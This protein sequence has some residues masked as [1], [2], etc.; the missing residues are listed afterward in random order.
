MKSQETHSQ[1]QS[2]EFNFIDFMRFVYSRRRFVIFLTV[3]IFSLLLFYISTIQRSIFRAHGTVNINLATKSQS[4]SLSRF[5]NWIEE[6]EMLN[7]VFWT[8]QFFE[9]SAYRRA[10]IQE[11]EG[12][13]ERCIGDECKAMRK[14]IQGLLQ[15]RGAVNLV[16]KID[17]VFSM[18]EIR[19]DANK[20][21]LTIVS[22]SPDPQIA[23]ALTTLAIYTLV[24]LNYEY[25]LT[26]NSRVR[27]F[28]EGQTDATG[29]ELARLEKI[30][31]VEQ[32]K[33]N[34]LSTPETENKINLIHIDN[35]QRLHNLERDRIS[36]E[37]LEQEVVQQLKQFRKELASPDSVSHVFV[38]QLQRRFD[39][40]KYQMAL[41]SS[42]QREPSAATG[43]Q[44]EIEK[45]RNVLEADS[46]AIVA[47]D[48]W[49]IIKKV[50]IFLLEARQ[51]KEQIRSEIDAAKQA[52]KKWLAEYQTMPE[53]FRR[54]TE[55]KRNIQITT[56][57]YSSLKT[58]LQEINIQEAERAND[59]AIL[60]LPEVPTDP[61]GLT[62][63]KKVVLAGLAGPGFSI[64]LLLLNYVLVPLVRNAS[65]LEWLGVKVIGSM[66]YVRQGS[67]LLGQ[68]YPIVFNIDKNGYAANSFR[69]IRFA[70]ENHLKR[71][72]EEIGPGPVVTISGFNSGEG[73]TFTTV[74][75]ATAF[76]L[77]D[78]RVLLVDID[79][80]GTDLPLYF[81]RPTETIEVV[82]QSSL[83]KMHLDVYSSNIH[84][85]KVRP[86]SA[87]IR[88]FV[89]STEFLSQFYELQNAY[90]YVLIDTPP[91]DGNVEAFLMSRIS[92]ATIFVVNQRSSLKEDVVKGIA[93]L[94]EASKG[95][96]LGLLNFSDEGLKLFTSKK[97][98]AA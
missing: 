42:E 98:I 2:I 73:K 80:R 49:E 38:S 52:E 78:L 29:E 94:K 53:I 69:Y 72:R 90:D 20:Y 41:G 70:L 25:L 60:A 79:V 58:R 9:S 28:L 61:V 26:K 48:P 27:K 97:R 3:A 43:A 4:F 63:F 83:V 91:L 66:R 85:L 15:R 89:Q 18:V 40:L 39:L 76:A 37:M 71:G 7:K 64:L 86:E 34:L 47:T 32:Q 45:Y 13:S 1:P 35:Q 59:L 56:D 51:K 77:S 33:H 22:S 57:L 55:L 5:T 92:D 75:L 6:Q 95:P 87:D 54:L 44:S 30:L 24:D 62:Y 11:I 50:E 10:L 67:S 68:K 84:V 23:H 31:V 17:A 19:N 16:E 8:E 81:G 21:I 14:L 96:I 93:S 46:Q 82:S 74:N 36:L 65:D 12:K 88:D